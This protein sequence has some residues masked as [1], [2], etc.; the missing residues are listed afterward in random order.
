MWVNGVKRGKRITGS[1]FFL[2]IFTHAVKETTPMAY[3]ADEQ[4]VLAAA[5]ILSGYFFFAAMGMLR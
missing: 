3:E 5:E 1:N 2:L 4:L